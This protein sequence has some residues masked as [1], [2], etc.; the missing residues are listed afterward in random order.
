MSEIIPDEQPRSIHRWNQADTKWEEVLPPAWARRIVL[1]FEGQD[2]FLS[3]SV[4]DDATFT[5]AIAQRAEDVTGD[6][7]YS[8]PLTAGRGNKPQKRVFVRVPAAGDITVVAEESEV[9]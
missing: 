8:V 9:G 4:A 3:H 2:G 1:T 5:N 7:K 6:T